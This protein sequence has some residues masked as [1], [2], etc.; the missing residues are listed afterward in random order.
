MEITPL[1]IAI[2][3]INSVTDEFGIEFHRHQ[4]IANLKCSGCKAAI[5]GITENQTGVQEIIAEQNGV[6]LSARYP[7]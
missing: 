5:N 1:L 4:L 2:L 7:V 3:A 6:F